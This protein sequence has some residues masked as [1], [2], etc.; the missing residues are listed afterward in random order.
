MRNAC[1][2]TPEDGKLT[3]KNR[4]ILSEKR[5]EIVVQ[6]TGPGIPQETLPKIFD[7]Y[8]TT[9]SSG[10]GL[11][12]AIAHRIVSEHNGRIDVA[13]DAGKGTTFTIN[14]PLSG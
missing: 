9:K 10:T 4:V 3:L 5:L 2:A 8:F 6:D 1:E 14:L 7:P 13:S 11:G 12:L